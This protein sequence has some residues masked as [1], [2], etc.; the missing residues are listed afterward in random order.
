MPV[1]HVCQIFSAFLA[2]SACEP[3]AQKDY[4]VISGSGETSP[5]LSKKQLFLGKSLE[6]LKS[7]MIS[8]GYNVELNKITE[9]SLIQ[10]PRELDCKRNDF[11]EFFY[12]IVKNS[13]FNERYKIF[14]LNGKVTCIESDFGFKNPY[15]K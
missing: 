4:A 13:K 6:Y 2:L 1:K 12:M 14:A 5:V 3:G 8:A 11:D 15:Q 10:V 7:S 9:A